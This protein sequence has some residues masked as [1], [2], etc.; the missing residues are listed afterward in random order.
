MTTVLRN[1]DF[2]FDN[3]GCIIEASG[4]DEVL[5]RAILRLRARRGAFSLDPELGSELFLHDPAAEDLCLLEALVCEALLPIRELRVVELTRST[6]E[7]DPPLTLSLEIGGGA[8]ADEP[9]ALV[10]DSASGEWTP[11][12][13]FI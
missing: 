11:L 5:E 6:V 3:R 10:L 12:A 1:G 2:V 4:R 7:G 13:A 9:A 8:A